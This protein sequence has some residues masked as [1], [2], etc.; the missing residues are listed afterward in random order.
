VSPSR[1][2]RGVGILIGLAALV[3]FGVLGTGCDVSP[4]AATVN[5]VTI[6]QSKLDTQLSDVAQNSY[7]R[8][9]LQLEG[10]LPSSVTGVGGNTVSSQLA[11][12]ELSTLI[13]GQLISRYL[14]SHH[15]AVTTSAISSARADLEAGLVQA[16][17]SAGSS[18]CGVAGRQL[19]E[20]LPSSFANEE[21]GFLSDQEL[22]AVSI[23]HLDLSTTGLKRYYSSHV[24][25]FAEVCLSDIEVLSQSQAQS[26][27]NSIASGSTSFGDAARADSEDTSTSSNGGANPCFLMSGLQNASILSAID[28]LMPGQV[29]QP[30]SVTSSTG[31]TAWLL[32]QLNGRPELP[33]TQAA[34]L[35][36]EMLL[37]TQ[38]SKVS[39]ELQH[40]TK[41]A[42]VNVDPRYGTWSHLKG[43][44]PPVPPSTK[45]VLAPTANTPPSVSSA[46]SG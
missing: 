33:F 44:T 5:G 20:R 39:E 35:A 7:S 13:L 11:S 22:L 28:A 8:C 25:A 41:A 4:A 12:S 31:Q 38:S 1:S 45:Y 3:S 46:L 19:V 37:G 43:V 10:G 15:V 16:E 30:V 36:R 21:V 34:T 26:I 27:R 17:Q 2:G 24:S 6:T 23:G 18:P 42:H 32:L 9:L 14:A 29:S 40:L